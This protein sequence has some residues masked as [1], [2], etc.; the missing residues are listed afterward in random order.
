[1]EGEKSNLNNSSEAVWKM[2]LCG[3]KMYNAF[4]FRLLGY[5]KLCWLTGHD[6]SANDDDMVCTQN[7][8]GDIINISSFFLCYLTI[9]SISL[10]LHLS[11]NFG[12]MWN[13]HWF[14]TIVWPHFD[15]RLWP[16][17]YWNNFSAVAFYKVR[18][19][20]GP[21]LKRPTLIVIVRYHRRCHCRDNVVNN[22]ANIFLY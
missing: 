14:S 6:G 15:F 4:M 17:Q 10:S 1:M 20:F 18:S 8:S 12:C 11:N 9:L 7:A 13:F 16:F 2:M 5:I 3:R 21:F 19:V 22:S